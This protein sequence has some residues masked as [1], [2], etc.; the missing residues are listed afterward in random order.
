LL[1]VPQQDLVFVRSYDF[2]YGG[3]GFD[4]IYVHT[5]P[6]GISRGSERH[7]TLDHCLRLKRRTSMT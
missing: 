1:W 2:I 6:L 4:I 3:P 7:D 5:C